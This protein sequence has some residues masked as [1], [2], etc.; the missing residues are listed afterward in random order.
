MAEKV[1]KGKVSRSNISWIFNNSERLWSCEILGLCFK[2]V[3]QVESR[4]N[5]LRSF[6]NGRWQTGGGNL[7]KDEWSGKYGGNGSKKRLEKRVKLKLQQD[8]HWQVVEGLI[9]E[10]FSTFLMRKVFKSFALN[11]MIPMIQLN[12]KSK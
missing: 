10:F 7:L 5:T 3:N 4:V 12:I 11:L 1:A 6:F 9:E 2:S 8:W